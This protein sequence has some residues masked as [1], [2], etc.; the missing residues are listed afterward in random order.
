MDYQTP[1]DFNNWLVII[2]SAVGLDLTVT[3][4]GILVYRFWPKRERQLQHWRSC[5]DIDHHPIEAGL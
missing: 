5:A 1:D 4:F 3:G 2:A